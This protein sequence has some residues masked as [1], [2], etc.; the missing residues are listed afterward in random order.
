[1]KV[2]IIRH[3]KKKSERILN[4][5]GFPD[6]QL[7]EEGKKQAHLTVNEVLHLDVPVFRLVQE[8]ILW[9]II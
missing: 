1:M 7:T 2:Y 6:M 3:G 5:D 8:S 4:F 9:D